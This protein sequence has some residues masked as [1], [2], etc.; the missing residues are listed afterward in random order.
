MSP[1]AI[2][3]R[4]T[5]AS[6]KPE[7]FMDWFKVLRN[8][9]DEDLKIITGTDAALYIVF[10]R[11]AAVFFA[12]L[13][14]I[15]VVIFI[16]IYVSGDPDDPKNIHDKDGKLSIVSL[17]TILNITGNLRKVTAA[18]ALMTIFYTTAAFTFMFFY[19]KKSIN[20]RYK[21]H[22]HKSIF[23]DHDIALHS[24]IV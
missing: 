13:S 5:L 7:G 10:N 19:W 8:M 2:R 6:A 18:Y 15:N 17:L 1:A 20:W 22:S 14:I 21:K 3:T 24:V 11:Y 9:T 16:P 12:A 4:S 23:H